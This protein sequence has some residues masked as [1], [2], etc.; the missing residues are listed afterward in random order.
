M[1]MPEIKYANRSDLNRVVNTIGLAFAAD[2]FMRWLSPSADAYLEHYWLMANV[3]A[4]LSIDGRT[5]LRAYGYEGAAIWLAPNVK[6]EEEIMTA[7]MER[8]LTPDVFNNMVKILERMEEYHP[9]EEDCWYLPI[10]GIDPAHQNKGLGSALMK[11]MT[12]KLDENGSLGYL[13]SSNPTNISLYQRHGFEVMGE[14]QVA[15]SPVITPMVR[16]RL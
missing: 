12:A 6:V 2:P 3:F 10:I 4:K 14:I 9:D 11:H 15:D 13:E 16:P 7:L 5:C 8:A 1:D